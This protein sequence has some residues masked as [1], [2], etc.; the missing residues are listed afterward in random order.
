MLRTVLSWE[1]AKDLLRLLPANYVGLQFPATIRDRK[2]DFAALRVF[3]A[4]SDKE[5]WVG[6]Y[7]FDADI[8][9]IEE[10]M[11]I[12]STKLS[13]TSTKPAEAQTNLAPDENKLVTSA[14]PKPPL[15]TKSGGLRNRLLRIVPGPVWRWLVTP[16]PNR[17]RTGK[18][19]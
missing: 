8:T 15:S 7:C 14:A 16:W 12:C 5:W 2:N 9:E 13:E 18:R 17:I 19:S 6:F 3:K 1:Q 4:E 10:A 11:Q